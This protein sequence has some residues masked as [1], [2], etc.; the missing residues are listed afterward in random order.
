MHTYFFFHSFI[1]QKCVDCWYSP[2]LQGSCSLDQENRQV[3]RPKLTVSFRIQFSDSL[4]Y[5]LEFNLKFTFS[6]LSQMQN[7][8]YKHFK[9]PLLKCEMHF[10][11]LNIYFIPMLQLIKTWFY[12]F[13]LEVLL[14]LIMT[15]FLFLKCLIHIIFEC[16]KT[17]CI[18]CMPGCWIY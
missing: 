6:V 8:I 13:W 15:I 2:S 3:D 17:L 5:C 11:L 14:H 12:K 4:E 7:I 9:H 16:L 18:I 10:W 1:L